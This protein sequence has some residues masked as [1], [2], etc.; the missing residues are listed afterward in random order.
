[1][2]FS[3]FLNPNGFAQTAPDLGSAVRFGLLAGDSIRATDTVKVFGNAGALNAINSK[4]MADSVFVSGTKITV[5]LSAISTAQSFMAVQSGTSISGLLGG[6]TLNAGVYTIS[7][8][9]VLSDTLTLQGDTGSVFIFNIGSNLNIDSHAVIYAQGKVNAKNIYWNVAGNVT[10]G[11]NSFFSGI[12]ISGSNINIKGK[13]VGMLACFAANNIDFKEKHNPMPLPYFSLVNGCVVKSPA[14]FNSAARA[15]C[16]APVATCGDAITN[17]NLEAYY[18][19]APYY[20]CNEEVNTTGGFAACQWDALPYLH[21]TITPDYFNTCVEG[22]TTTGIP[23]NAYGTQMPHSGNGYAGLFSGQS[24]NY[25]EEG[26]LHNIGGMTAGRVYVFEMYA[27]LAESSKLASSMG[28]QI[29]DSSM[30]TTFSYYHPSAI[31][32]KANWTPIT[33]CYTATGTEMMIWVSSHVVDYQQVP[34]VSVP[35]GPGTYPYSSTWFPFA[36]YYIDDISLRP[37]AVAG[38]NKTICGLSTN[39]GDA[40]CAISGAQYFW[41]AVSGPGTVTFANYTSANTNVSFSQPGTYQLLLS[42]TLNGCTDTEVITVT[43]LPLPTAAINPANDSICSGQSAILTATGGIS[44]H[45]SSGLGSG[46]TKTVSP[47]ATTTY[48]VTVTDASNCSATAQAVVTVFAVPVVSIAQTGNPCTLLTLTSNIVPSGTYT[49][50]WQLNN[51]NISGATASTYQTTQSGNYSLVVSSANGCTGISNVLSVTINPFA[52]SIMAD[53]ATLHCADG[54]VKLTAS[55]ANQSGQNVYTYQWSSNTDTAQANP[56]SHLAYGFFK[57]DLQQIYT[58]PYPQEHYTVTI[59]DVATGCSSTA[60][61]YVTMPIEQSPL[62]DKAKMCCDGPLIIG[63]DANGMLD[64]NAVTYLSNVP[65]AVK[66]STQALK[67]WGTL[68][69]DEDW[70]VQNRSIA[71]GPNAQIEIAA[72]KA[73]VVSQSN[74]KA[75]SN[76]MWQGI[77]AFNSAC[78]LAVFSS[79][80]SEAKAAVQAGEDCGAAYLYSSN[81]YDNYVSLDFADFDNTNGISASASLLNNFDNGILQPNL[82]M[83]YESRTKGYKAMNLHAAFS[84]TYPFYAMGNTCANVD[85]G[86]YASQSFLHAESNIFEDIARDTTVTLSGNAVY[87]EDMRLFDPKVT[88]A[89]VIDNTFTDCYQGVSIFNTDAEIKENNMAKMVNGIRV[90]WGANGLVGTANNVTIA[91]NNISINSTPNSNNTPWGNQFFLYKYGINCVWNPQAAITISNNNITL[92]AA[93]SIAGQSCFGVKI[94]EMN[95]KKLNGNIIVDNFNH[96]EGGDVGYHLYNITYAKVESNE[97]IN[98]AASGLH[99]KGILLDE[100]LNN[101]LS[102]NNI[103]ANSGG[104]VTAGIKLVNSPEN[105][106]SFN[107]NRNAGRGIEFYGNSTSTDGLTANLFSNNILGLTLRDAGS[108]GIGTQGTPVYSRANYFNANL[109]ELLSYNSNPPFNETYYYIQADNPGLPAGNMAILGGLIST[110]QSMFRGSFNN[111]CNYNLFRTQADNKDSASNESIKE[112]EKLADMLAVAQGQPTAPVFDE[113]LRFNKEKSVF[114]ELMGDTAILS[115]YS[116]LS[117]FYVQKKAESIGKIAEMEKAITEITEKQDTSISGIVYQLNK[118]AKLQSVSQQKL[119]FTPQ[120]KIEEKWSDVTELYLKLLQADGPESLTSE[121]YISLY[122]IAILCP[123]EYGTA[124][125]QARAILNTLDMG[126]WLDDETN[127]NNQSYKTDSEDALEKMVGQLKHQSDFNLLLYPNPASTHIE[128]SYTALPGTHYSY[129]VTDLLGRVLLK[130]EQM[131]DTGYEVVEVKAL[132]SGMY[133]FKCMVNGNVAQT[134]T[135]IVKH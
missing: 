99:Y 125:N 81:F 16:A 93:Q 40:V 6:Q 79:T 117:T 78:T 30:V 87:A 17:G 82:K 29:R 18:T 49:Y 67:V 85:F 124:V 86:I 24:P 21:G 129:E 72:A 15:D 127:C 105:L 38:G 101:T 133:F 26:I 60:S 42:A 116:A 94:E 50:Q 118:Q 35:S 126:V 20:M 107:H 83:P 69:V 104:L 27:N 32:D 120:N 57:P 74:L 63:K 34:V 53:T 13:F 31:T 19:E 8:D 111:N 103:N 61:I 73:L 1:M 44:Y 54:A 76:Y 10:I 66:N 7:G 112:Q 114:R 23:L 55:P 2:V 4:V 12:V 132:A 113:V 45:W 130:S 9:A 90:A 46:S 22:S 108:S 131:S 122:N 121:D 3:T 70:T 41:V 110:Y 96:V 43:V 52:A 58:A 75:C 56:V 123:M 84:D 106:M 119:Q 115:E 28:F 48:K 100:S 62:G 64:Y 33:T 68:I 77:N 109:V 92:P 95:N 11:S 39:V 128:I 102:C 5:A 98:T 91:D 36:Y 89:K 71:F 97:G 14:N 51:N 135:F 134:N 65:A 25:V 59:T 88:Y 47:T 80:V 37:L